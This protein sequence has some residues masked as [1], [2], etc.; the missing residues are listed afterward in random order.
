MRSERDSIGELLVPDEA[1]YGIHSLRARSNFSNDHIFPIEWYKAVHIVKLAYYLT[2]KEFKSK[3]K[4]RLEN[5]EHININFDDKIIESIIESASEGSKGKYFDNFIVPAIQGGAGT[6]INMNINEI[7]ANSSLLKMGYKQGDY[8]Y[9]DPIDHA[10]MFQSTNDVIPSA[11]KI[12]IINLLNDLEKS[13]NYLRSKIEILEE[14]YRIIP[15]IAYTQYQAAVPSSY[16]LLFSSYND[17]LSRDWWRV[18]KCFERIKM[19]NVGGS[20]VGTGLSVPR[21]FIM[22]VIQKLQELTSLPLARAENM[23]DNTQNLDTFVEIHSIIKANAVNIEKI[24]SD[25]RLLA[26]DIH[27]QGVVKILKLQAGSSIMPGKV[28]PVAVEYAISISHQIY[29]NDGLISN[30]CGLGS[31]DLNPYLPLIG[32][33]FI[34]SLKLLISANNSLANNLFEELEVDREKANKDF[35]NNP[36]ITTFLNTF[37]GYNKS[38]K[39][40]KAMKENSIDIFEANSILKL[41]DQDKLKEMIKVENFLKLG[42][43]LDDLEKSILSS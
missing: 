13:I 17:A 15:R 29:A 38:D 41:I 22:N 42:F 18:S 4:N 21:Y 43:S 31:L 33:K 3:A 8:N 9:V 6:S 40:A 34:E 26:S 36:S 16:G 2:Y 28:N 30:L 39:L 37:I 24:S 27:N 5:I 20:A 32:V 12:A 14:K 19:L 25:I 23:T 11:L 10:N 1:L 35:V 7:I